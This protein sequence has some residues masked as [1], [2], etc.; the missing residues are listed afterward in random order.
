M[1]CVLNIGNILNAG[2]DQ[3]LVMYNPAVYRTGDVLDTFIYR[4][5][6]LDAQYSLSTA[7]GLF[8][9]VIGLALTLTANYLATRFTN[10]RVF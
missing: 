6:L 8:K 10:Y 7:I 9:S 1:L 2:F 3:I 5:G 4:Q